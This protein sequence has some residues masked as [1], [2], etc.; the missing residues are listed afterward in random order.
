MKIID[1]PPKE[2]DQIAFARY[3]IFLDLNE[4]K[5]TGSGPDF[6]W[7]REV[8]PN[9]FDKG[10]SFGMVE[11]VPTDEKRVT[12]LERH[13]MTKEILV[14]TEQGGILT[15]AKADNS[16]E[17]PE[18]DTIASFRVKAGTIVVLDEGVW[19]STP[20][21]IQKSVKALIIFKKNTDK[22]DFEAVELADIADVNYHI[23]L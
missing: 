10:V 2:L 9:D 19:H 18:L 15:A 8:I 12:F 4:T 23:V 7:W 14:F 13:K 20:I 16:A 11:A 6:T 21:A 22:T 3:G 17:R 1:L 5:K